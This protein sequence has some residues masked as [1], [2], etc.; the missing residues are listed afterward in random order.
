MTR[1]KVGE[2]KGKWSESDSQTVQRGRSQ[3]GRCVT[4]PLRWFI[5]SCLTCNVAFIPGY[6]SSDS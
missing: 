2:V 3:F 5:L 1:K 4:A 6:T